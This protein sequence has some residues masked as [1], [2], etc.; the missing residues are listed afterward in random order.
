MQFDDWWFPENGGDS[1]GLLSWQPPTS[2]FPDGLDWL[3][4]PLSLY[5][6]MYSPNN[7]WASR[8]DYGWYAAATHV[9]M[10]FEPNLTVR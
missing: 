9:L 7:T 5:A 8:R 4:M 3:G 2:V 6:A 1:G 10:W